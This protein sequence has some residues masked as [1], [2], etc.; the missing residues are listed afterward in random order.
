MSVIG[1]FL[2]LFALLILL[3]DSAVSQQ[4]EGTWR[5]VYDRSIEPV[6]MLS[7]EEGEPPTKTSETYE[8]INQEA[9]IIEFKK[10]SV[11]IH[12]FFVNPVTIPINGDG[13][14]KYRGSLKNFVYL[15]I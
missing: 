7:L 8:S 12:D 9:G 11:K 2:M 4:L 15:K 10:D 1:K 6:Y 13:I 5:V 14:I 3:L